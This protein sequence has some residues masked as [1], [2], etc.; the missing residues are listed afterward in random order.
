MSQRA[1]IVWQDAQ[2]EQVLHVVN[3]ALTSVSIQTAM[4][5]LSN[6]VIV[7]KTEGNLTNVSATPA[8]G[9]YVSSRTT[10][11]LIYRDSRT[12]STGKLYIPSPHTSLFMG[13]DTVD[14]TAVAA[15]NAVVL[16]QLLAGSGNTV[17]TF[18]GGYLMRARAA[19][20]ESTDVVAFQN[21]M[22]SLGDMI[23]GVDSVGDAGRLPIGTSGQ[24]L[25]VVS[26]VPTWVN[27]GGVGAV[28]WSQSILGADVAL[29]A[30][31][32]SDILTLALSAGTYLLSAQLQLENTSLGDF[33]TF[34]LFDGS[35]VIASAEVTCG[36][37][38][39]PQQG[40][41]GLIQVAPTGSVTIHL[42][43]TGTTSGSLVKAAAVHNGAGNNATYM[44]ALKIA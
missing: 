37:A 26:G 42:R 35:S 11:V 12:N 30:N 18:V 28:G 34:E 13:G 38:N 1:T 40:S 25:Q 36:T 3:T 33:I 16:G 24:V 8:T 29:A 10:A 9:A 32:M 4:L 44:G 21:P 39:Q 17:D 22:T 27:P 20:L 5:A 15:L 31:S 19:P 14:P 6:A 43:A 2:G 23:Y 41:L 7:E